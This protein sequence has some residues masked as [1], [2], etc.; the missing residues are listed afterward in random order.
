MLKLKFYRAIESLLEVLLV[1]SDSVFVMQCERASEGDWLMRS[2]SS[3]SETITLKT[4]AIELK[5]SEIYREVF[6]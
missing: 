3:L 2:W 6:S 4:H 1:D 5:L